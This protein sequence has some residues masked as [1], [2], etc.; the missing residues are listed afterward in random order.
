MMRRRRLRAT[1]PPATFTATASP[2][3]GAPA[4]FTFAVT[5]KNPSLSRRPRAYASSK[6]P[7]RRRRSRA[8]RVNRPDF[9]L[10]IKIGR[11]GSGAAAAARATLRLSGYQL[12]PSLGAATREHLAAVLGRHACTEP[13]CAFATHFARLVGPL[14]GVGSVERSRLQK[15]GGK[16]KPLS[17]KVSIRSHCG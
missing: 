7:L 11:R 10:A 1:A 9:P 12:A 16:A 6:S 14:H 13:V 17:A 4:S 5:E 15:K 3:R 8:G 2:R